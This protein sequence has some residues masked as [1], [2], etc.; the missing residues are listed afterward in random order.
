[1]IA[2]QVQHLMGSRPLGCLCMRFSYLMWLL[3]K[4]LIRGIS[5]LDWKSVLT[6]RMS[7][8]HVHLHQLQWNNQRILSSPADFSVWERMT[9]RRCQRDR[10]Y[11]IQACALHNTITATM[12]PVLLIFTTFSVDSSNPV[13]S[14]R[15]RVL[16]RDN[17]LVSCSSQEELVIPD[18]SSFNTEIL[19]PAIYYIIHNSSFTENKKKQ[20]K[21]KQ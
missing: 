16:I 2:W 3:A 9:A 1:M 7:C 6:R 15:G 18:S 4:S 19:H 17:N 20:N 10:I 8:K 21:T 12:F 11:G 13:K 5:P 14:A